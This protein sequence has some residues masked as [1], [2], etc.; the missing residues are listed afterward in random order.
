MVLPSLVDKVPREENK[1]LEFNAASAYPLLP[2][3]IK[4][5]VIGSDTAPLLFC[6]L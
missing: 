4:S 5:P 2:G 1:L 6:I 3:V